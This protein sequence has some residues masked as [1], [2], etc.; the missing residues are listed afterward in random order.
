MSQCKILNFNEITIIIHLENNVYQIYV[1]L[2]TTKT[3]SCREV[4]T[5]L[6][7]NLRYSVI[8]LLINIFISLK[9]HKIKM[10]LVLNISNY[11]FQTKSYFTDDQN[12]ITKICR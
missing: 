3:K 7:V 8:Q 6:F 9:Y 11:Y 12:F 10:L 5:R 4:T 1:H 2:Q